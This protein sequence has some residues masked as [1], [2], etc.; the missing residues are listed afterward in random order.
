MNEDK[1]QLREIW[2]NSQSTESEFGSDTLHRKVAMSSIERIR[3][4]MRMEFY[5]LLVSFL[6]AGFVLFL[7]PLRPAL[8]S[9][10]WM[11]MALLLAATSYFV[12]R[13]IRFY[14]RSQAMEFNTRENLTWFVYEV[15]L[16]LEM[17]RSYAITCIFGGFFIGLLHGI[18]QNT[19]GTG[20]IESASP[21][22]VFSRA[23]VVILFTCFLVELWLYWFYGRHVRKIERILADLGH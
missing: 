8:A 2:N 11:I 14:N 22:L 19:G 6:V 23:L 17:Y 9:V 16:L 5:A 13:V 10:I 20:E 12:F 4:S 18:Q 3:R 1:D 7:Y 21:T 15:R